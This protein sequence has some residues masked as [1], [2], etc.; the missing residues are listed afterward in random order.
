MTPEQ[1][2]KDTIGR[3]IDVDGVYGNQCVDLFHY[4]CNKHGIP[5]ANTVTGWAGGL[6]THRKDHY[7]KYFDLVTNFNNLKNGD[8]I[9]TTNPE[10][11]AMWYNGQ[12]LGENQDGRLGAVNLKPFTGKFLGAYRPRTATPATEQK[13]KTTTVAAPVADYP[14]TY[15]AQKVIKGE[16]GNGEAR[17][18]KIYRYVQD[19]VN[20]F[21]NKKGY[22]TNIE[23]L[24]KDV[25]AGKY[26]NGDKRKTGIYT[27]VQ[28]RV[29][30][31]I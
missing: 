9:F 15:L 12:M 10:H 11:V 6:W 8:W 21:L 1:F 31:L 25:V 23:G 2:Y 30:K 5:Y 17:K 3:K 14:I 16:F 13:P 20:Y 26:G 4:Y 28:N 29:N 18:E 7:K 22:D 24:I 27:V 19:N